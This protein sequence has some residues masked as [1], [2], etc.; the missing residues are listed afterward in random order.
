MWTCA[1]LLFYSLATL[2]ANSLQWDSVTL[3]PRGQ[4]WHKHREKL[5][6]HFLNVRLSLFFHKESLK[7][8]KTW[9]IFIIRNVYK[10]QLCSM[11]TVF[12]LIMVMC[13]QWQSEAICPPFPTSLCKSPCIDRN[14]VTWQAQFYCLSRMRTDTV[15]SSHMQYKNMTVHDMYR[16]ILKKVFH[17]FVLFF[18]HEKI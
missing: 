16:P 7:S 3:T 17:V 4:Y 5:N 11:R 8:P 15:Y 14:T 6:L 2:D 12:V 9:V 10:T 1:L 13:L 18:L